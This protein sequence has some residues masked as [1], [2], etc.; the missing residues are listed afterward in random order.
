[1]KR[2]F[3]TLIAVLVILSFTACN[4]QTG[5]TSPTDAHNH[6]HDHIHQEET[7]PPETSDSSAQATETPSQNEEL[8]VSKGTI[9]GNVYTSSFTGLKFTKPESFTYLSDDE[10]A[11]KIEVNTQELQKD[12]FP[13]TANRV[14]AVYDMWAT[15]KKTGINISVAYENM[16]VSASVAMTT[17]EYMEMLE[18][19]FGNTKGT[20]LVQ[21]S[22]VDL[23]GQMYQKA[24]FTTENGDTSTQSI[25]YIRAMD[26]FMNIILVTA[27]SDTAL[28]DIETM[29]S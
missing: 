8:Q 5:Q 20:A 19:A 23:S 2:F 15:D 29:F 17:D 28:P 22:T 14:P 21:K 4:V 24:I 3:A 13:F 12:I 7:T 26:K 11:L 25:Y 18:G 27:P 9:N 6:F 16:H 1:M 10:L